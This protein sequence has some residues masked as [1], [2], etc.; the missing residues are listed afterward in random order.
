MEISYN[1][2]S[3]QI[4][5]DLGTNLDGLTEKE[6]SKR[7]NEKGKNTYSKGKNQSW[8]MILLSQFKDPITLLL[9][10]VVIISFFTG[11]RI[12]SFVILVMLSINTTLG[13]TQ[14][15]RAKKS[16]ER[17]RSMIKLNVKVIREGKV[18]SIDS[19]EIV[20]GDVILLNKGNMIPADARII[21]SKNLY[22]NESSLT[23]ESVEVL[24]NSEDSEYDS[25]L[26]QGKTNYVFQGTSVAEGMAKVVVTATGNDT[27]LGKSVGEH[28][29]D[30]TESNYVKNINKFTK[31]LFYFVL[32]IIAI[33]LTINLS[34]GRGIF[35]SI[36]LGISLALGITPETMPLII[37]IALSKAAYNL[38]KENVL[39]KRISA[40]EDFGNVDTICSDKTGTITKG[41]LEVDKAI[42]IN[43]KS[44]DDVLKY[45]AICNASNPSTNNAILE[46]TID[47]NIWK[48]ATVKK[49]IN[50]VEKFEILKTWDLDFSSRDIAVL[51]KTPKNVTTLIV[52]GAVEEILKLSNLSIAQKDIHRKLIEVHEK[53]GIKLIAVAKRDFRNEKEV[54]KEREDFEDL[55]IVGY[56]LLKDQPR[57]NMKEELNNLKKLHINL[58]IL[59]GDTVQV[60]QQICKKVGLDIVE[61]RIITGEEL[62]TA[63]NSSIDEFDKLV[64]KYNIFARIDPNQKH[65]I[66]E[67]LKRNKHVVAY[68]GDGIN[69]VGAL[70]SADVG[71][72]V[73]SAVD[74]A[75]DTADIIILDRKLT[76]V[77]KGIQEGRKIFANTMKFIFST[78]SSSFGNV[79]TIVFA[80]LFLKF[81]PLL[82]VQ[83]I[84]LDSLSDFQHLAISTDSVDEKLTSRPRNWNF[85]VFIKYVIF[86]GI[87]STLFDFMHIIVI[88]HFSAS[89]EIFRSTWL[90]E[91]VTTEILAT[92]A[93]RTH[94][95]FYKSKPSTLMLVFSFIPIIVMI[96]LTFI[97]QI[98][99]PFG[100][101]TP[102]FQMLGVVLLIVGIYFVTLEVIKKG[103]FKEFWGVSYKN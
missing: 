61:N 89:P 62:E 57:D 45:A 32:I 21:Y 39:I 74:V 35:E 14:E 91:S 90:I 46:N 50:D 80:S 98:N 2:T 54:P 7:L 66:I 51:V 88:N 81:I 78:M 17:L 13:F 20:T 44:S 65:H 84:L 9:L 83:V 52:K 43:G 79:I 34:L 69:D 73:D 86:W 8:Q 6:A 19:T 4:F 70:K 47:T 93:L 67:S 103:Y 63:L 26:P 59:T 82:P 55:R 5:K 85:Q 40:F 16:L 3:K 1:S 15:F 33:V 100:L 60:T 76:T 49:E 64:E 37:S 31:I 38:S 10:L 41:E 27:I 75:K 101:T 92:I 25:D 102:T 23:G 30:I 53:N 18:L 87:V 58:K 11:E 99:N 71:I 24:K 95:P 94:M 72:A 56:I 36:V 42:D 77:A 28:H 22:I 48:Y 29:D 97:P 96:L 12:N 68:I